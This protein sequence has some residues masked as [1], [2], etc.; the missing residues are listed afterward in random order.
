MGQDVII[1]PPSTL[2]YTNTSLH[3]HF[4]T[5]ALTRRGAHGH[6]VGSRPWAWAENNIEELMAN[7][8][9][10]RK[11]LFGIFEKCWSL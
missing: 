8:V 1:M 2:P 9:G 5:L 4:L 10:R 11:I 6:V 7:I 3:L